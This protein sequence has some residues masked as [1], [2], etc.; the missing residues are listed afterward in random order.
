M[1]RF[2]LTIQKLRAERSAL[3]LE[4]K[5]KKERKNHKSSKKKASSFAFDSPELEMIFNSLP[6]DMQKALKGK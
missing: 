2:N 4:S 6:L 1:T 5:K 3:L